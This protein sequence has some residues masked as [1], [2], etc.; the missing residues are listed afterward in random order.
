M[1]DNA[2][3]SGVERIVGESQTINLN[4][5]SNDILCFEKLITSILFSD[6]L[7]AVN[8]YKEEYRVR[9]LKKFSFIDFKKIDS[10][11]YKLIAK[12]AAEFAQRC[13]FQFEGSKPAGEVVAFFDALRVQPQLRW[14]VFTSSEYLTLGFLVAD[15]KDRGYERAID[16]IF[17]TENADNIAS[18]ATEAQYPPLAVIGRDDIADL[19]EL[20]QA[21]KNENPRFSG[22]G[23]KSILERVIFG[24]GWSAERTFFYNALAEKFE[25]DTCLAPLRDAFCEGCLRVEGPSQVEMLIGKMKSGG[26]DAIVS[27]VDASGRARFAS[28]IPFFSSS[29]IAKAKDARECIDLA[30]ELRGESNFRTCRGLLQNLSHLSE[31]DRYREVNSI[32][33]SMNKSWSKMMADYA[34]STS[35]GLQASFSLGITGPSVSFGGKIGEIFAEYSNRP[36]VRL[37]RNIAED[38]LNVE[39]MGSLYEKLCS[40]VRRHKDATRPD[41]A[42]TS[43]FMEHRENEYGRP[44]ELSNDKA[45]F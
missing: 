44:A 41:V 15:W 18:A 28:K 8:D 24:Y 35:N 13:M 26:M 6:S 20:Y 7:I 10:E 3:L 34:V 27:I 40:S 36:F 16:S 32:L 25:T 5:I 31:A 1:I 43:R 23:H 33:R 30:L 9:R 29:L 14:N 42:V 19:K 45:D 4:N 22:S 11:E 39:R 37:F 38:M 12:N 17:R 2:T 21:F